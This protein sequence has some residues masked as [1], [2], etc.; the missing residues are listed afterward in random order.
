MVEFLTAPSPP[1]V[2]R[3]RERAAL[4]AALDAALAGRG[5]LVLISG[6]AGIGKTTLS[7]AILAEATVQGVLALVGR[8]YD[9]AETSPYGPWRELFD[10][11]PHGG[12]LPALPTAILPPERDG[13]TLSSRDAIVARGRAYLAALAATRPLVL[14]LE[15]LHWADP[16]SLDLLRVAARGL[17]ELPIL[18]LATYR[19]DE[20]P[21]GHPLVGLIPALVREARA[22]RIDLPP[23]D[24]AAIGALV[25]ARYALVGADRDRLAGYLARRTEGNAL[26]LGELLRTL[27]ST[28]ELRREGDR[29][30]L[31]DV[32]RVPIPPLLGQVIAARLARLGDEERRLLAVAA[33]IGQEVSFDLWALIGDAGEEL[34]LAVAERAVAARVQTPTAAGVRFA[35]ALVREAL[36][37]G[38][39][40]P[41]RRAWHR[42]T[43]EALLAT[44][45]PDA[46]A[47]AHHFQQA[48]DERAYDW[49]IRAGERA[50]GAYA[51][52]TAAERYE[53]ALAL[54]RATGDDQREQAW[55]LLRIATMLQSAAPAR[56][57]SMLAE[58]A[59]LADGAGESGLAAHARFERGVQLLQAGD[60]RRGVALAEDGVAEL[61]ELDESACAQL[62]AGAARHR[63]PEMVAADRRPSLV[64]LYGSCGRFAEAVRLGAPIADGIRHH[65]IHH[66]LA[67]A[68][69]ALGQPELALASRERARVIS[70]AA[71]KHVA[72]AYN[73]GRTLDLIL[74]YDAGNLAARRRLFAEAVTAGERG[75]SALPTPPLVY[76]LPLLVVEGR[77]GKARQ[78][79]EAV[80]ALDG[81]GV[82]IR[83]RAELVLL[84]VLAATGELGGT[85]AILARHFPSGPTASPLLQFRL[86]IPMMS[87]AAHLALGEGDLRAAH[88]WLE[89]HD[90]A[91]TPTGAALW[92][93]D[94]ALAW[95]AYYRAAGDPVLAR[96]HAEAALR[97][98]TTPR[99]PLALLAAR[100]TLGELDTAANRRADAQ[101]HLDAAL[102]LAVACAAP[103]ERALA[104]LALAELRAGKRRRDAATAVLV[105]TRAILESLGARPALARAD[106]LDTR[107]ADDP[108]PARPGLPFELTARESEVLRLVAAG[109]TNA[110]VAARLSLSPK[111]VGRHLDSIY[112]KLAVDNRTA[113]A[114]V[115][116][117]HGLA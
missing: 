23:L 64:F 53:A 34:L 71:G 13:A 28:G 26:F 17:V 88:A 72:L 86:A 73:A 2:G 44:P 40:A 111:T 76:G 50:Q 92:R 69:A 62:L 58:V 66:G 38:I 77:W 6:T 82:F 30:A 20:I 16:A 10:R 107:L 3:D 51:Y 96:E 90:R 43:A 7:E 19:A 42:Q 59:R 11:A 103:Y 35:H 57:A 49:L 99:Q 21:P 56:S 47:V 68:Y 29:W 74:E 12:D 105:E 61:A 32:E 93:A 109:L 39:L 89:S 31:G 84:Q 18:L 75:A 91:L 1:L 37:A 95:A 79:A 9:L 25:A 15:D 48:R 112:T 102:T 115:A 94:G 85:R 113:V 104:L 24:A 5:S 4:R 14:L 60:L 116:S 55:V 54:L 8:A 33:V 46:D 106:A 81:P 83:G 65:S 100:R 52:V 114:R 117:D 97:G 67:E 27:E 63:I 80:L 36:Y 110:E 41:R 108:L 101:A 22:E 87:L 98:A 45:H 70:T 78:V